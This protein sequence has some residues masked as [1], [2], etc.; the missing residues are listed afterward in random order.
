MNLSAQLSTG[1]VHEIMLVAPDRAQ[2]CPL[3]MT[4][5]YAWALLQA[6]GLM[7]NRLVARQLVRAVDQL[8]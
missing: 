1:L 8:T 4:G 5:I 2:G 6:T 3:G 7:S